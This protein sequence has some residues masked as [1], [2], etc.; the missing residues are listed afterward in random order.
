MRYDRMT[1]KLQ[2]SI[3]KGQAFC[4]QE[5]Q[6]SLECEHL[7]IILLK[8][9][10]SIA[11]AIIR[12]AGVNVDE[13]INDLQ[14][15]QKLFPT[16]SGGASQIYISNSLKGMIDKGFEKA[17]QLI[18]EFLSAEHFL[19]AV[20]DS[21]KTGTGQIFAVHGLNHEVL[22]KAMNGIRGNQKVTDQ[23]EIDQIM[24]IAKYCI[25]ETAKKIGISI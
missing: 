21:P 23:K 14:Q 20:A 7:L 2:D 8:D 24:D 15:K 1:I 13:L 3:A 25:D 12:K 4:E 10:D 11:Q 17:R 22:S 19:L 18:D 6:Q 5:C 16:I 9:S